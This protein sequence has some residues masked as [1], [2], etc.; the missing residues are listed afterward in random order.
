MIFSLIIHYVTG[1]MDPETL[2][3][4]RHSKNNYRIGERLRYITSLVHQRLT[5]TKHLDCTESEKRYTNF[6]NFGILYLRNF[7]SKYGRNSEYTK[8]QKF[9]KNGEISHISATKMKFSDRTLVP[10]FD[11]KCY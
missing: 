9:V 4:P 1:E 6:V 2:I 10:Y 5:R 3:S 11:L 7:N 8:I